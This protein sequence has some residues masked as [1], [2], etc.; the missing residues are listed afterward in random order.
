MGALDGIKLLDLTQFEAGTSCTQLLAWMGAD[1]LKVEPPEGEPGRWMIPDLQDQDSYYFLL[2]N[3]NKRAITLDLKADK[4]RQ[5]FERLVGQVD[6]VVENFALRVLEQLD[7]GYERLKQ[8]KPDIIYAS[9]KGYGSWGPYRDY[10]SFDMIA[11]ASG[12]VMAVNGTHET[13]PL[14]PGVTFGDSGTGVHLAAAILAAYIE[15]QRTGEGQRVEVSMQDAM[16]NFGRTAFLA[17]YLT[18][19]AP[20]QRYGNRLAPLSP[21]DLYPSK[22]GGPNDFVYVMCSTKRMWHGVLRVVGREDLIGDERFEEQVARNGHWDEVSEMISSW[23]SQHDKMEV[24]RLMSEAG[25][26]CGA[27]M[28]SADIFSDEHLAA[29]EMIVEVDHP[30]RGRLKYPGSPIKLSRSEKLEIKPAPRLGAHNEEV[31]STLGLTAGEIEELRREGI[32]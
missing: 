6:I 15:R 14:K 3:S 9:I 23:T 8:I 10:K 18:G 7:L 31:L 11:Q 5:I 13:P 27:V 32:I 17:H 16:V 1:V 12:G 28:D 30:D 2:F 22:G 26:P 4:G 19:G 24:M 25:V 21:S 20:A 29:R